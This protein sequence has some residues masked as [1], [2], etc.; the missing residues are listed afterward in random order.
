VFYS[1]W[2]G[3]GCGKNGLESLWKDG[4]HRWLFTSAH[5]ELMVAGKL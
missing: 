2:D 1:G 3:L 4:C 5:D